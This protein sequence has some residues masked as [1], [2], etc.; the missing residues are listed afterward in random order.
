M[1]GANYY[2]CRKDDTQDEI[3]QAFEVMGCFVIDVHALKGLFDLIAIKGEKTF[4]I[5]CKTYPDKLS[6]AEIKFH[7]K[8]PAPIYVMDNAQQVYDLMLKGIY[9]EQIRITKQ[10]N[11][12]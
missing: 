12:D 11:N 7:R 5:E 6:K 3:K 1:A 4:F 9:N 8:C 2:R 10:L